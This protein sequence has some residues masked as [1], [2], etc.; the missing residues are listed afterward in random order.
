M[1][2]FSA[3]SSNCLSNSSFFFKSLFSLICENVENSWIDRLKLLRSASTVCFFDWSSFRFASSAK[4]RSLASFSFS[5]FS[6][7]YFNC[8]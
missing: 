1:S 2:I 7:S 8:F 6:S 3:F 4:P 5:F